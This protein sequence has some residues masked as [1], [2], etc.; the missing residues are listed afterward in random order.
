MGSKKSPKPPGRREDLLRLRDVLW[1]SIELASFDKRAPLAARLESVLK[2]IEDLTPKVRV[3]DP[4]DEVAARR[5]ARG[6]A[7]SRLGHAAGGA[8]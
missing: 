5:A 2:Q 8:G 3:G 4:I 1:E 7:T 6:G